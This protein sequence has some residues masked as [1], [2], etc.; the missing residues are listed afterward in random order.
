M[1]GEY[2]EEIRVDSDLGRVV[3]VELA[4]PDG[5]GCHFA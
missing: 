1:H 2:A 3:I 4:L 5:Y